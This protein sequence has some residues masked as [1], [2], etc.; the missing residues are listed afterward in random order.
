MIQPGDTIS[1]FTTITEKNGQQVTEDFMNDIKVLAVNGNLTPPT[2]PTTGQSL[3]L[4]LALP[5]ANIATLLFVE[6]KG[7]VD[8]VLDAPNAQTT[9]PKPYGTLNWQQPVP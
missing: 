2:S 5:P 1:L 4:I 7:P 6:Q 3:T 8:A 9:P